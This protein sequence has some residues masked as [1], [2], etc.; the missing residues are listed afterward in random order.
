MPPN[1]KGRAFGPAQ[2]SSFN[3]ERTA[4]RR[5]ST[6]MLSHAADEPPG[7]ASDTLA[8]LRE[9][10]HRIPPGR[11]ISVNDRYRWGQAVNAA[12]GRLP[13]GAL[14]GLYRDVGVNP[15]EAHWRRRLAELGTRGMVDLA[16]ANG[17]SWNRMK[18][19]M[20]PKSSKDSATSDGEDHAAR[21]DTQ[22]DGDEHSHE[23]HTHEQEP[24]HTGAATDAATG[25]PLPGEPW[26]ELGYARRLVHVYGERLRYV[27]AWRRWLVWDGTRWAHDT[28]GQAA[29]WM[30]SIARL[31]MAD[32]LAIVEKNERKAAIHV[33]R[34]GESSAGVAGALTLA[35]TEADIAVSPD[36]LDADPFL[37][38]CTNG[39]L[40]LRTGELRDH[41]PGDLLTKVTGAAYHPD[42]D[43]PEWN[44]FL[45]RVQPDEAMRAY[46]ARLFGQTLEGRVEEHVLP[47][48]HGEGAN[49]KGTAINAI[50]AALGDY[51]D[52]ADPE[53]LT[54]RS[55]DAHP[56]G[57]ADLFGV[58]LAILH[59]TDAGRRLAEGTVKRLTGGDRVKA[60]RM[61]EDFWHFDPSHTF[62]MLTNHK[63]LVQGTDEGIWRRIRLV[64]WDVVIPAEDRDT[65]FG[66]RLA[67]EVDAVLAWLV[68]GYQQWRDHGLDEPD[69]VTYATAE[70]RAESD[71]L[72]R[73][74]AERCIVS[75]L[76]TVGSTE[77]Y[78]QWQ[79]WCTGEGVPSEQVG[80]QTSF[81]SALQ[82]NKGYNNRK[83]GTGRKRWHGLGLAAEED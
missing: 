9:E 67:L 40:D 72:G 41:D 53:L 52:A 30:K 24:G 39:T 46:L 49:G 44:K 70:F 81:A 61:R 76:M 19:A 42:A 31:L 59:E 78:T 36:D 16:M 43:G 83:D 68:D 56:T 60:R 1:E 63:P 4:A 66:D 25:D 17:N 51:G 7:S 62:C 48:C 45:K 71:T 5:A 57:V 8:A 47:I 58:R 80:T 26:S 23:D 73:F 77:L 10:L 21:D 64:P 27:P 37:L 79:R 14:T 29:R 74:I 2:P 75:P 11:D 18:Q 55:F 6:P 3:E 38:N 32:A 33:T 20:G 15:S 65:K 13:R 34:R 35:S 12:A 54:A 50:L 69:R 22:A 82:N 28:T